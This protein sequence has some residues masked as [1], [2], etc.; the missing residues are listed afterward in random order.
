MLRKVIKLFEEVAFRFVKDSYLR[1]FCLYFPGP[2]IYAA[3][4]L[5]A[6]QL[7]NQIRMTVNPLA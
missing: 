6:D 2:I 5:I 3:C 4:L 7:I 1:D